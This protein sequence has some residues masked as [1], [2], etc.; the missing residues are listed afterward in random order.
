MPST[1]TLIDVTEKIHDIGAKAIRI[2]DALATK[3]S[4]C[5]EKEVQ[6]LRTSILQAKMANRA[7]RLGEWEDMC[8]IAG[9]TGLSDTIKELSE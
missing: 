3:P 2:M 4:G 1:P 8:T 9:H 5:I 7:F 6:E